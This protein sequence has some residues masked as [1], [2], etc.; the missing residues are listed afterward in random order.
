MQS[1]FT[2]KGLLVLALAAMAVATPEANPKK[3]SSKS[4]SMFSQ[5]PGCCVQ[6]P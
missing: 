2:L 3:K 1:T 4:G 5:L 6:V